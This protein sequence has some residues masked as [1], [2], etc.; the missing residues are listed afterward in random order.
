MVF[1]ERVTEPAKPV[2]PGLLEADFCKSGV[3]MARVCKIYALFNWNLMK[4]TA[5]APIKH[6]EQ[7]GTNRQLRRKKRV[8]KSAEASLASIH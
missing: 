8:C 4:P 1:G 5:V 7:I 3:E 6:N 2:V